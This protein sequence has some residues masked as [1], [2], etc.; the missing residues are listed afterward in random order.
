MNQPESPTRSEEF[1]DAT[2]DASEH[3]GI[4]T[5][6]YTQASSH[7]AAQDEHK[8]TAAY[9]K[10]APNF[11]L[12]DTDGDGFITG[13]EVSFPTPSLHLAILLFSLAKSYA[14]YQLDSYSTQ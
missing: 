8:L 13:G 5:H 14:V 10:F 6:T 9:E 12:L 1:E 2:E 3:L 7:T 11:G 4:D